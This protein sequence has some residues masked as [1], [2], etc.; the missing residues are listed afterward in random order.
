MIIYMIVKR[1]RVREEDITRDEKESTKYGM[2]QVPPS[3]TLFSRAYQSPIVKHRRVFLLKR[4]HR[5]YRTNDKEGQ[6][7]VDVFSY[8]FVSHS[9]AVGFD[10][11]IPRSTALDCLFSRFLHHRTF[12]FL[13]NDVSVR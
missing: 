7:G 10:Q 2:P 3:Q 11:A 13:V 9:R 4:V 8:R 5:Q 1:D 6:I 12:L